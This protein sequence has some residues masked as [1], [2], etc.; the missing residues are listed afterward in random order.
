MSAKVRVETA[1]SMPKKPT[2]I[3]TQEDDER[4]LLKVYADGSEERVCIVKLPRKPLRFRYR[5]VSLDK[6]RKKGFDGTS[7]NAP[8]AAAGH[9]SAASAYLLTS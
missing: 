8:G 9:Q 4:F 6:S 1:G 3:E 5:K 7:A 2:K